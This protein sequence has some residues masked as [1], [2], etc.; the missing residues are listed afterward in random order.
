MK[1]LKTFNLPLVAAVFFASVIAATVFTVSRRKSD[2]R[3]LVAAKR[4]E[5]QQ[6]P[7]GILSQVNEDN[8]LVVYLTS[9][10][11]SCSAEVDLLSDVRAGSPGLRIVGVM[12]EDES[13]IKNY[14]QDRNIKF[15]IIADRNLAMLR[16]LRLEYFPTNL[17]IEKGVIKRA[18]LGVPD[19]KEKML[20]FIAN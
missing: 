20:T 6:L 2:D 16:E 15:P 18:Y 13:Q 4:L 11:D 12:A 3:V 19:S 10:C 1:F 8:F 17:K 14:V 7:R 9:T 5:G